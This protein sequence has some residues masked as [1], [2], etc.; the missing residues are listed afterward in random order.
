MRTL[1]NETIEQL[2]IKRNV[3]TGEPEV[4]CFAKLM[5]EFLDVSVALCF[6]C[7]D[8]LRVLTANKP[9]RL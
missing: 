9:F 5:Q 8:G 1:S 2:R 6:S 7:D 4:Y 3:V